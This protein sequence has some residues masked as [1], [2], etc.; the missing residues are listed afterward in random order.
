MKLSLKS[1]FVF[2][3]II[4][5]AF[6][7]ATIE[8]FHLRSEGDNIVLEWKVSEENNLNHYVIKRSSDFTNYFE[9]AQ[10]SPHSGNQF[11][12]YT[13]KTAYKTSDMVF[14]YQLVIVDND[15]TST[16]L[17]PVSVSHSVSAVKRTWG[18]IKA[19]FR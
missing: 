16:T 17:A 19:M 9:I 7:G 15:G 14:S 18:S 3:A 8:Y 5:T 6:A 12:T 4:S 13:D 10:V 1:L 11:Y 2:I